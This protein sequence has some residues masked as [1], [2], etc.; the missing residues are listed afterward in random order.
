MVGKK[1]NID[2]MWKILMKDVDLGEPAS[3]LDHVHL[4]CTERECQNKP[5]YCGQSGICLNPGSLLE[6]RKNYLVQN[7]LK[8]TFPHGPMTWKVMQRNARSDIASWLTKQPSSCTKSQLHALTIT[9]SRKKKWDLLENCEKYAHKLLWNA[10]IW[11]VLVDL[12]FYG[13]WTSLLV[14]SRSGPEPVT[15]D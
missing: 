7:T 15:N 1:Q 9:N 2:S 14:P 4:G 12:I 8:Q 13:P 10:C 6:V 5:R 11:L 3:F